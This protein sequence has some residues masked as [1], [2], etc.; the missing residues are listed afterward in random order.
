MN[1]VSL[2]PDPETGMESGREERQQ[3]AQP[4]PA[5]RRQ[6]CEGGKGVLRSVSTSSASSFPASS[7]L[8][9][10]RP[11]LWGY[12]LFST[13]NVFHPGGCF[14]LKGGLTA[15]PRVKCRAARPV[16]FCNVG[17]EERRVLLGAEGSL[18]HLCPSPHQINPP[19]SL[20]KSRSRF[21]GGWPCYHY[22]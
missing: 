11:Q 12:F 5:V 20:K 18:R 9:V 3:E 6:H 7:V 19:T 10:S 15:T 1:Q 21:P 2:S 8:P 16:K 13:V 4:H 14:H 22:H 17:T